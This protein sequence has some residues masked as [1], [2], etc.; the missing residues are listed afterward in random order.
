MS[1]RTTAQQRRVWQDFLVLSE[2]VRRESV[3]ELQQASGLSGPDYTVL[4]HL[5]SVEDR[6]MRST[7]LACALDWDT[8]RTSHHLRR[9]EE[10]GL[11]RR[12]RGTESD[13]RAA[14]VAMTDD[15]LAVFRRA[16]GPHFQSIKR[17]FLDGLSA[18]QID[19]LDAILAS[20]QHHLDETRTNASKETP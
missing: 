1:D 12:C 7:E 3:R 16:V 14:L 20:L 18:D 9:M 10:R 13:G 8:G 5:S 6:A 17:W 2:S 15:G 4:A 11:I 19:Q